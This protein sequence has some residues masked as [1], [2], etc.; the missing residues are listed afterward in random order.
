MTASDKSLER[1]ITPRELYFN[2][3]T[4]MRGGVLAASAAATAWLYRR[5]NGVETLDADRPAIANLV[6]AQPGRGDGFVVDE[7]LTSRASIT[8]YNNFYEFST[9]KDGVAKAAARFDT[10]GWKITVGGS[11]HKPRVFDLD[12]LRAIGAPE[13]RIYR[14]RCVEA[15]SMVIPWAGLPLAKLLARVEPT[16]SAKYVAFQTLHDPE[17]MPNQT[18]KVLKWPYVEGL[19]LDEAMHPLSLLA[20][21]LYGQELPPQDGAPVRLV[22]PW[23]YG[24]KNIKSIV[25]ITLT[26]TEPPSTW[27]LYAPSEYGFYGNVNPNHDHPRWSQA[28]EQRIGELSRR[29][30]LPFNGYAEQVASLYA[31]MDL[32][33]H[34]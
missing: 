13:E 4:V 11:V 23:K 31:G 1:E 26:E 21:G 28:T 30:T 19:R 29:K 16:A 22:T 25:K 5:L 12:D 10:S 17:R 15:W 27:N 18:T 34:Y 6:K 24:F 8:N 9:D 2:R 32:D 3:R 20:T 14:M 33:V 7:P